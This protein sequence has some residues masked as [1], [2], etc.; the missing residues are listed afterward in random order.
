MIRAHT[1]VVSNQLNGEIE[2]SWGGDSDKERA[3][4]SIPEDDSWGKWARPS[5]LHLWLM[6]YMINEFSDIE[7]LVLL[8]QNL[9]KS[10]GVQCMDHRRSMHWHR[11]ANICGMFFKTTGS[12]QAVGHF[13]KA[14]TT[15]N[16]REGWDPATPLKCH[17][18]L[19]YLIRLWWIF[20]QSSLSILHIQC[21]IYS[22]VSPEKESFVSNMRSLSDINPSSSRGLY[23]IAST[24]V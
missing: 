3:R 6:S 18:M 5:I 8:L 7:D 19:L 2:D 24:D 10:T 1:P 17:L 14:T 12:F 21:R 9:L 13:K 23:L 16:H 4:Q 22:W 20:G 11:L 15:Q